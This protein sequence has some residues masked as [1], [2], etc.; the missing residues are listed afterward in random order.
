[1][2]SLNPSHLQPNSEVENSRASYKAR[3]IKKSLIQ[4]S[5]IENP[6]RIDLH[7]GAAVPSAPYS[8]RVD[9]DYVN[10]LT[11]FSKIASW[12]NDKNVMRFKNA[13]LGRS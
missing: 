2:S 13:I 11:H 7:A 8:P 4:E 9:E 6:N 10:N 5:S 12:M 1:M 3:K